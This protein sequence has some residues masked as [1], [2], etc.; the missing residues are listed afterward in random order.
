MS[1][2]TIKQTYRISPWVPSL[3]TEN[4]VVNHYIRN[5]HNEVISS[6]LMICW[7]RCSF[8]R[9]SK[10]AAWAVLLHE[11]T[12]I[13]AQSHIFMISVVDLAHSLLPLALGSAIQMMHGAIR[14]NITDWKTILS[15]SEMT[16]PFSSSNGIFDLMN[17]EKPDLWCV[18]CL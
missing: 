2:Q 11:I 12:H 8:I 7:N 14:V 16:L 18:I 9:C 6:D 17:P 10:I 1:K 5:S 15:P 4:M 3:E 13:H